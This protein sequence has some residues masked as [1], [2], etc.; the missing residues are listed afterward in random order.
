M[1]SLETK[2]DNSGIWRGRFSL[3]TRAVR[4]AQQRREISTLW[5]WANSQRLKKWIF[6]ILYYWSNLIQ[7]SCYGLFTN[8][9]CGI[10]WDKPKRFWRCTTEGRMVTGSQSRTSWKRKV[11]KPQELEENKDENPN[12]LGCKQKGDS[13]SGTQSVQSTTQL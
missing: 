9:R 1:L 2:L 7:V 13:R 12:L 6:T 10:R 5:N 3:L 11:I 4:T 8:A